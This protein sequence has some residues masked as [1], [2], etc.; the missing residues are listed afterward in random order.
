M[1]GRFRLFVVVG[2]AMF[3]VGCPNHTTTKPRPKSRLKVR[4]FTEVAPVRAVEAASHYAFTT[5]ERGLQRW[6][7]RNGK[8]ITLS[9]QT[10]LPGDRVTAMSRDSERGWVWI[11]TDGGVTRYDVKS[12]TFSE[13]PKPPHVLG[14]GKLEGVTLASSAD[15]GLWIGH[16]KGLFYTNEAGQWTNTAIT[17]PVTALMRSKKGRLWIGTSTGLIGRQTSG[18]TYKYGADEGCDLASVRLMAMGPGQTPVIVGENAAGKQ[19]VVL[20]LNDRCASYRS[21]PNKRWLALTRLPDDLIVLTHKRL[22]SLRLR[23]L[24]ARTLRRDGMRL[25]GIKVKDEDAIPKTPY[26]IRALDAPVPTGAKSIASA[27]GEI[28]VGTQHLGTA[29]LKLTQ[30]RLRWLREGTLVRGSSSLS[31]ACAHRNDCYV[32]TGSNNIWR[33]NGKGFTRFGKGKRKVLAVARSRKGVVLVLIEGLDEKGIVVARIEKGLVRGTGV[34]IETPGTKPQVSF[35]RF[36]PTEILWVGLS[37]SDD[38]G[39]RRPYGVALVDPSLGMVVY[40]HATRNVKEVRKGVLPIPINVSGACFHS[41]DEVWLATSEGAAQV[42]GSKVKVY[43]EA[44]GLES[45][46]LYAIGCTRGGMVY[47]ASGRGVG[48]YDGEAWRYRRELRASVTD[49]EIAPDGRLWMGS[50]RGVKVFDGA[51]VRRFDSRRGLLDDKVRDLAVDYTGRIWIRGPQGI[52]LLT[53]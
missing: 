7:L 47:V 37:Y 16:R 1:W 22:Y 17:Q 48:G 28:L 40:H 39:E 29:R 53:P 25:I 32:A 14:L 10:G 34:I 27:H 6:D 26:I 46:L 20:I 21:S 8:S 15:G 13:L 23:G 9:S 41:D 43:T 51:K 4:S 52:T 11:A 19:R 31:V 45:E 12:E 42:R 35:A 5:T 44:D 36:S 30:R 38:A 24:G 49:L 33:W 3:A 18:D 50:N 2:L